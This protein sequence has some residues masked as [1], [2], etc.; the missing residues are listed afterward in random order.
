MLKVQRL[1]INWVVISFVGVWIAAIALQTHSM[2]L[3]QN[4]G[5]FTLLGIVGAIFANSTGAGG[6]V[7]F[8]PA[9]N[10]LNFSV[11]QALATSFAIQCMGMTSGA[12]AWRRFYQQTHKEQ[13]SEGSWGLIANISAVCAIAC[14]IGLWCTY[15]FSWQSPTSLEQLFGW[16]SLILGSAILA[17]SLLK[18]SRAQR[19]QLQT[20][21]YLSLVLVGFF[22]GIIT[23]WLSVGVGEILAIY[24]IMRKF[25]VMLAIASA[26]V[27]SALTVWI[28][29]AEHALIRAEVVWSVVLFAGPGAIVGAMLARKLATRLPVRQLKAF[30]ALWVLLMGAVSLAQ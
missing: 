21:D 11:E 7:V 17:S 12:L 5:N 3:L 26:V 9:F 8:I 30:F 23:A 16:F 15:L 24:L 18:T 10:H 25:D 27:V 29:V 2:Q 28:G 13:V 6:G 19:F 4:Y 1:P 20:F 22:G 14:G